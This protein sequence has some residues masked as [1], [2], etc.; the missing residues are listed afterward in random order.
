MRVRHLLGTAGAVAAFAMLVASA[1]AGTAGTPER[2]T[3]DLSTNP[4]VKTYLR[5]L[6]VSPRGFVIQRGRRNYAGPSC[7]GRGWNCTRSRRVVQIATGGGLTLFAT[8]PPP[9]NVAVMK[10]NRTTGSD[11]SCVVVQSSTDVSNSAQISETISQS[12]QTLNAKQRSQVTQTSTTGSNTAQVAMTISQS[13][14]TTAATVAQNL[15][16]SQDF[17][18]SQNST[19]GSQSIQVDQ[20]SSQSESASSATDGTQYAAGYLTG[21]FT[22]SGGASIAKVKQTHNISESAL[23][24]NVQQTAIDP[25]RCCTNTPGSVSLDQIGSVQTSGDSSPDIQAIYQAMCQAAGGCSVTE[26]SNINGNTTTNSQHGTSVTTG[27]VCN[28]TCT[29]TPPSSTAFT[30]GHVLVSVSNGQVEE[31]HPNGTFVQTLDTGLGGFTTGLGFDTSGR[32]YVAGFD[33]QAV[34]RFAPPGTLLG[35]FG[36][37]YDADPESID[38]DSFGNVY[39]GQA[40]GT[41]RVLKFDAAGNPAGS[42]SP[43]VENRGTDW[44]DLA[45][46]DCTLYYTSEGVLVKR[47]NVCTNTQLADFATLPSTN[48][49]GFA[50]RLLPAGGTLV[51]DSAQIVRLDSAGNVAQTYDAE[52]ENDWFALALD[53]NG[54]SFWAADNITGDVVEFAISTGA[55]QASFNPG[56]GS[57]TVFGLG[58]AP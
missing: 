44:I 48:G 5:S 9:G 45:P 4:A 13:A 33:S 28:P 50:L 23:G 51:A 35:T 41:H 12:G 7:P 30:S 54:T 57:N 24:P 10:C 26:S 20:R 32:L 43:A 15:Q 56:T 25:F 8:K 11:Q 46:D 29:T 53:P 36:S 22:Q 55:V 21:H 3:I 38:F 27:Q 58:V 19:T 31:F 6:G 16:S 37:G 2:S 34:S 1:G 52:G 42:F 47:F 39:V 17:S 18:I 49:E 40:D 14:T